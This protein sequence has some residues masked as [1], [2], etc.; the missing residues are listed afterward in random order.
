MKVQMI[1]NAR[2]SGC[3]QVHSDIEA[4]RFHL[5]LHGLNGALQAGLKIQERLVVQRGQVVGVLKRNHHEM[6]AVVGILIENREAMSRSVKD[7]VL[8]ICVLLGNL[9]KHAA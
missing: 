8:G 1:H 4:L 7:I 2:A 6:P 9:A 5:I 3:A